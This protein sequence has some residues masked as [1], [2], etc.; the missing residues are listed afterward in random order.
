MFRLRKIEKL[1]EASIPKNQPPEK[2]GP[3]PEWKED[4]PRPNNKRKF[5]HKKKNYRGNKPK[6]KS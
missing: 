6:N 4:S 5:H 3:G 1:I 2:I